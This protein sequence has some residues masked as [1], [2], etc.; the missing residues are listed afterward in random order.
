[1]HDCV[2]CKIVAG[3]IECNKVYEDDTFI[4]FLDNQPFTEGHTL[5]IPKKHYRWVYDVP[6]FDQYWIFTLQVTLKIQTKLNPIFVTYLTMGNEVP[7]AHIHLIPRY[8]ND[9]LTGLF[10]KN[11]RTL[12][13][14]IQLQS[15]ADKINL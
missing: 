12:P 3:S 13:T 5:V 7:H 10:N 11:L 6:A 2:F 4:A 15:V 14:Y 9:C 1:V 8:K